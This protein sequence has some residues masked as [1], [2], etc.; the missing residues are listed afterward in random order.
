MRWPSVVLAG[1]ATT[2]AAIAAW[3]AWDAHW[4]ED[5]KFIDTDRPNCQTWDAEPQRN[6]SVAWTGDCKAGKANGKGVLT[7]R[8]TNRQGDPQSETFSGTLVGGMGD[9]AVSI[10]FSDGDRYDGMYR[11][12]HRNGHGIS[13]RTSGSRFEGEWKDG[14][15]NGFGTYTTKD[16]T[17]YEG[18]WTE[19]C[20]AKG[21]DV[22]WYG[23]D[24]ET[25]R[26]V[27][28]K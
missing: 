27:L 8:Y 25:C 10:V 9:G 11:N 24:E 1:I 21:D 7:W 5:A 4:H 17:R 20:L 2:V 28:K 18:D 19:G 23:S 6:E 26:K 22:I 16:G 13:V 12:G 14:K 3:Q 15:P